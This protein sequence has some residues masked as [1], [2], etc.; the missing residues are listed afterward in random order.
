LIELTFSFYGY[1]WTKGISENYRRKPGL[2]DEREQEIPKQQ[3]PFAMR[4][5]K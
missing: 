2:T 4:G 1:F 5:I 3:I